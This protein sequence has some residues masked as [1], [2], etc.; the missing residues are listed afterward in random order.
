MGEQNVKRTRCEI[1]TRTMGYYRPISQFNIGKRAE[2]VSRV[3]F[4]EQVA[5][6]NSCF[7]E[8]YKN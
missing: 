4:K 3:A 8:E 2:H 7:C 1:W 6:S 5:L